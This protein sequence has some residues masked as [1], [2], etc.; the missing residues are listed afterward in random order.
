MQNG[1][2]RF[3]IDCALEKRN[4]SGGYIYFKENEVSEFVGIHK[5]KVKPCY[6]MPNNL[7]Y[8]YILKDSLCL[9]PVAIVKEL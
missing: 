1:K 6:G 9:V 7:R 5:E 3:L 4:N 8:F 2:I